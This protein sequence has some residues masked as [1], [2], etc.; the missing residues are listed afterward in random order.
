[1]ALVLEYSPILAVVLITAAF[2]AAMSTI[3][4][5]LMAMGTIFTKDI[6]ESFIKKNSSEKTLVWVGRI[7]MVVLMT[8]SVVWTFTAEGSIVALSLIAFTCG[9][10]L[11]MPLLGALF[12]K[13]AGKYSANISLI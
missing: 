12:Y 8:I 10:L 3:D 7:G 4:S 9:S 6:W 1:P 13:K 2:A 11:F 5:Q